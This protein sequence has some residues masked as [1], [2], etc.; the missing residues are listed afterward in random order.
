MRGVVLSF[1]PPVEPAASSPTASTAPTPIPEPLAV[2]LARHNTILV[3]AEAGS[4]PVIGE[5][6]ALA[7]ARE[8][9]SLGTPT[10]SLG[11]LTVEGWH[12]GDDASTPLAVEDRL[13]YVVQLT[14]LTLY[15]TE[16]SEIHHEMVVSIDALTGDFVLATTVR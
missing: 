7:A 2:A 14:G 9:Y 16:G 3:P 12:V 1:D 11:R 13:V 10:V 8:F 6:R 4:A 5:D 15:P